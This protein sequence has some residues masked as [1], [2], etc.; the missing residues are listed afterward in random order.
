MAN[1]SAA[2]LLRCCLDGEPWTDALLRDAL[3]EEGGRAFFRIVVERLGDLF[4]PRLCDEYAR[5]FARAIE[6]AKP[7]MKAAGLLRRYDSI[8]RP[9]RCAS[10]PENVFVLSRVTLGADVAVTSVVLDAAKKRFPKAKIYL[11]G[12]RKNWE[13]FA[14]DPRILHHAFAYPRHGSIPERLSTWPDLRLPNSIVIDPDSRL[15]QLGLLPVCDEDAYY[16][17]ES[18]SYGGSSDATLVEL[19]KQWVRETFELDD[20]RAWVAPAPGTIDA[21]ITVSFGVGD[22]AEKRID[23]PFEEELLRALARQGASV[24]IDEGAGGEET[25]RV[26]KLCARVPGVRAWNGAYAPFA[27]AIS[28]AKFYAGYDSAGQHVAAA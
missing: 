26:R 12:P 23:D 22:N 24:L 15:S 19:T 28:R 13:L 4:E 21:D 6:I 3:N 7:G 8:R 16:F 10:E 2:K 5:L 14:K 25:D 18:R 9:R 20:S 17:F 27:Y 11:V 1:T